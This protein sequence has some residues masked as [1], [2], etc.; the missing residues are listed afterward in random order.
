V[1]RGLLVGSQTISRLLSI[2]YSIYGVVLIVLVVSL[3]VS[4]AWDEHL[5]RRDE[6]GR[7]I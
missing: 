4:C 6:Y 2:Q 5:F 3:A 7:V 1:G